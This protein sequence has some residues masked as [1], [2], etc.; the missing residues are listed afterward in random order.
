[1][2]ILQLLTIAN[3][4]KTFPENNTFRH[5]LDAN[6]RSDKELI[7]YDGFWKGNK[8]KYLFQQSLK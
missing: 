7:A 4:K 8:V 6:F 5:S 3:L 1:V 2:A